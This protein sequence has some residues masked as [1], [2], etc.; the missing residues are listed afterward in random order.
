MKYMKVAFLCLLVF[1]GSNLLFSNNTMEYNKAIQYLEDRG[2]VCFNF[3]IDSPT[4]L[5]ALAN[6]ISIDKI[7]GNTVFA[8]ANEEEFNK[9][10]TFNYYYEVQIPPGLLT[11]VECS[12]YSDYL[13]KGLPPVWDQYPRH[14]AYLEIMDKFA[15]DYPDLCKVEPFGTSVNGKP[16]MVATISDNVG[17]EESEPKFFYQATIHG[18]ETAPFIFM[19]NLIEYLL[20]NYGSDTRVTKLVDNIEIWINPHGNPDGSYGTG[21]QISNPR[22]YNANNQD[23]NRDF[24]YVY[25]SEDGYSRSQKVRAQPETEAT[26]DLGDE[27][28]FTM[29]AD[30]HAGAELVCFVWGM[31]SKNTA[32]ENWWEYVGQEW[33]DLAQDAS[34]SGYFDDQGDGCLN[35]Y[36]WYSVQGERINH[37]GYNQHSRDLTVEVSSQ[38]FL[39]ESSLTNYWNYQKESIITYLEQVLYGIH[40]TVTDSVTGD[41]LEGVEVFVDNHDH[42]NSEVY[43]SSFGAYYRPI[44]AGTYDITFSLQDYQSKTIENV[45]ATNKQ[46]TILDVRLWDGT[47]NVGAQ[48]VAQKANISIVPF[49]KG[50]KINYKNAGKISNAGIFNLN[51]SLVQLLPIKETITWDGKNSKGY[52]TSNGCYIAKLVTDK[53]ILT[54]RF[55]LTR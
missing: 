31:N 24:P 25:L 33:A 28:V 49:Q 20:S 27:H 18:D 11:E 50:I 48:Y 21:D 26:L 53:K 34:P 54:K 39:S 30:F 6:I 22:R 7:T 3:Y 16:L 10:C 1:G 43:T 35:C 2:E 46:T 36:S 42:D 44:L 13:E 47:T 38:K 17:Q 4:E 5:Q 15:T 12:D 8:Y 41:S 23:L 29:A 32:D 14:S 40:G 19:L 52:T 45:S 51:G 55:V 37:A 9:F